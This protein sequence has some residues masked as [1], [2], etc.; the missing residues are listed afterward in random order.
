MENRKESSSLSESKEDRTMILMTKRLILRPWMETDAENLF[1][2][3]G[4]PDVG[5]AA[6][7]PPHKNACPHWPRVLGGL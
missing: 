2:Y 4:D 3:A 6:G 1:V 5:P 7:W